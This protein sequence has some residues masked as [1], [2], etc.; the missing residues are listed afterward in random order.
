MKTGQ[1]AGESFIN[2]A[3]PVLFSSLIKYIVYLLNALW[4]LLSPLPYPGAWVGWFS[5]VFVCLFLSFFPPNTHFY[6]SNVHFKPKAGI[7][8]YPYQEKVGSPPRTG[9]SQWLPLRAP[10]CVSRSAPGPSWSLRSG[11]EG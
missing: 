9:S 2:W 3:L 5:W 7:G 1:A 4:V 11:L 10:Q 8:L 6:Y